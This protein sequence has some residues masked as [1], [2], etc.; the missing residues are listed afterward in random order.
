MIRLLNWLKVL[1][2]ST[3]SM[4]SLS[5][6]ALACA[7][8]LIFIHPRNT[9]MYTRLCC[10]APHAA[11]S[12]PHNKRGWDGANREYQLERVVLSQQRSRKGC[13][14]RT[15]GHR[16]K[17]HRTNTHPGWIARACHD[18]LT[19]STEVVAHS[20]QTETSNY[21][22]VYAQEPSAFCAP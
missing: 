18:R 5:G 15:K 22:R 12:T 1:T 8:A 7:S 11:D 6:Y 19:F 9:G 17:G 2:L 20:H 10:D 14:R 16:T 21:E 4:L 3:V 13:C